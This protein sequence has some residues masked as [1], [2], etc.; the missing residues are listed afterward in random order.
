MVV[1]ETPPSSSTSRSA[2]QRMSPSATTF[3]LARLARR[4]HSQAE[5]IAKMERAGYSSQEIT[6]VLD[7][8]KAW[9]YMDD[10]A[11]ATGFAS[12]AVERK[13]WGPARVTKALREKGLA[14]QDIEEAVSKAYPEG[15]EGPLAE[16]LARFRRSAGFEA[17][18]GNAEREKARAYRHLLARGFS[19]GAVME[20][21]GRE[22]F[23]EETELE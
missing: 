11:F 17:D 23:I 22:K 4:A 7:K 8:L 2:K 14:D 12:S 13:H 18:V 1:E 15:E 3:A 20:I 16:A 9:R 19:P 6:A 21:L 5:L 10:R